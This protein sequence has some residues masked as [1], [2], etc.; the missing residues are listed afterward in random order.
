VPSF[1]MKHFGWHQHPCRCLHLSPPFH[2]TTSRH[3]LPHIHWEEGLAIWTVWGPQISFDAPIRSGSSTSIPPEPSPILGREARPDRASSHRAYIFTSSPRSNELKNERIN[4]PLLPQDWGRFQRGLETSLH[5]P[6]QLPASVTYL[7]SVLLV[8]SA[9][10]LPGSRTPLVP[11]V[12]DSS[13]RR[14]SA[15]Y[16]DF[17]VRHLFWPS[18]S[19]ADGAFVLN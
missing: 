5:P 12:S 18:L 10:P 3:F 16:T 11:V 14:S 8:E 19:P 17:H 1:R 6:R 7:S 13:G 9:R 4:V 2:N 15:R